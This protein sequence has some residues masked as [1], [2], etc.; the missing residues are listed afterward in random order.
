VNFTVMGIPRG[1]MLFE[2][3][4][5][6]EKWPTGKKPR[7]VMVNATL[8]QAKYGE[9]HNHIVRP[10]VTTT[11]IHQSKDAYLCVWF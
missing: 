4:Y 1:C 9:P 3:G 6:S 7:P 10:H 11:S 5:G 8:A 2:L